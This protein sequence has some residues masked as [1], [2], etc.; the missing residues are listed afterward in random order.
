MLRFLD[1]RQMKDEFDNEVYL[2]STVIMHIDRL[3]DALFTGHQCQVIESFIVL[4]YL[5]SKYFHLVWT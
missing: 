4:F 3:F 5:Y 1:K 2:L